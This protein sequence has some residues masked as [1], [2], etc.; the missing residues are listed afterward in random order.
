MSR[1]DEPLVSGALLAVVNIENGR[2]DDG[3]ELIAKEPLLHVR[4]WCV[5]RSLLSP[6]AALS[7]E[8]RAE[9]IALLDHELLSRRAR[10]A[11]L[12]RDVHDAV[13]QRSRTIACR[14]L[15]DAYEQLGVDAVGWGLL[16]HV[17]ATFA[18]CDRD[19]FAEALR[20]VAVEHSAKT[21]AECIDRTCRQVSTDIVIE[22]IEQLSAEGHVKDRLRAALAEWMLKHAVND[23]WDESCVALIDR[24][25]NAGEFVEPYTWLR[26]KQGAA[27]QSILNRFDHGLDRA[28]AADIIASA[29]YACGHEDTGARFLDV[30][31]GEVEALDG[32]AL[33]PASWLEVLFRLH[34][35]LKT[36]G[37]NEDAE[38]RLVQAREY[39]LQ[40]TD[41][42]EQGTA[43]RVTLLLAEVRNGHEQEAD[44]VWARIAGGS[45]KYRPGIFAMVQRS[46]ETALAE[47]II[48]KYGVSSIV[49]ETSQDGTVW[50][51]EALGRT[52]AEMEYGPQEAMALTSEADDPL[53]RAVIMVAYL[54]KWILEKELGKVA[55][56]R[57]EEMPVNPDFKVAE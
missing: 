1:E 22:A 39:A 32:K 45:R 17:I 48:G 31:E 57:F 15:V 41:V 37:R 38:R 24:L 6:N 35:L 18:R 52:L 43:I 44:K 11:E 33:Y 7:K 54:E 2:F 9:L 29:A 55:V 10:L 34:L 25:E 26:V 51:L 27:G 23:S 8:Q 4:Q 20:Y 42:Y 30:M 21:V 16:P 49:R 47:Y 56:P 13:G 28:V 46:Q 14:Q 53:H 36:A 12:C 5:V 3:K 40:F 50:A 19:Q